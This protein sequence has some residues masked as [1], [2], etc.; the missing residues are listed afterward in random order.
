MN[1]EQKLFYQLGMTDER[2]KILKCI[3][4]NAWLSKDERHTDSFR[5]GVTLSFKII[6]DAIKQDGEKR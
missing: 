6:L 4:N 3:E 2:L 1:K 5:D